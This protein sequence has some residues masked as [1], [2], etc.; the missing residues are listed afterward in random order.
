[1][2]HDLKRIRDGHESNY[3]TATLGVYL[4]LFNV[5]QS[6]LSL[7]TVFGGKDD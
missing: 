2:L 1:M 6:L 5:F 4:S 7:L 3:I